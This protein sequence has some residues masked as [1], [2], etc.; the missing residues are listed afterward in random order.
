MPDVTDKILAEITPDPLYHPLSPTVGK[1][2]DYAHNFRSELAELMGE[3]YFLEAELE[4][5]ENNLDYGV[6]YDTKSCCQNQ[7]IDYPLKP[8]C[9]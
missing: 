5:Y 8:S 4:Q 9:R 3:E 7:L 1:L 6:T 2:E